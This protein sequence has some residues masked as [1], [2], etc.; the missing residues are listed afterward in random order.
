MPERDRQGCDAGS[1][2]AAPQRSD[3]DR[4]A[5]DVPR[6]PPA[7]SDRAAEGTAAPGRGSPK[8]SRPASQR[9]VRVRV[10]EGVY[11]DR[12]GLG[13]SRKLLKLR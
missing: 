3:R 6:T 7:S 11:K 8:K 5:R 13:M 2:D 12:Y 10:A 4:G 1:G 9:R